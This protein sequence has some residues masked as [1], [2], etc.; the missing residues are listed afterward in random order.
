MGNFEIELLP[1]VAPI[2]K[3]SYR[4]ATAKLGRFMC[5]YK[6]MIKNEYPL[7]KIDDLF[8]QLRGAVVFSKVD[9][10]SGHHQ[11]RIKESDISKT[12]FRTRYGHYEFLVMLF[13]IDNR[14]IA[15]SDSPV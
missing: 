15:R 5:S 12:A 14:E 9:L 8:D 11:L 1:R 7:P 10:R 6:I 13:G 2:S 3:V 4:M